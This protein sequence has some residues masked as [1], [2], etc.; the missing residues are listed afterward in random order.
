MRIILD[1]NLTKE[2]SKS[3]KIKNL[4]CINN[5]PFWQIDLNTKQLGFQIW[6]HTDPKEW[7]EKKEK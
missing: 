6:T 7:F 3:V 5:E 1:I 2:E 4:H